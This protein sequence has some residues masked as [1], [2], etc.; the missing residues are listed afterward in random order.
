MF[1]HVVIPQ[2]TH[3]ME[4]SL[5]SVA[6]GWT[7]SEFLLQFEWNMYHFSANCP[8][9]LQSSYSTHGGF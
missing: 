6:F 9:V 4:V 1:Y 3:Y 7:T 2:Q 8:Q 5:S